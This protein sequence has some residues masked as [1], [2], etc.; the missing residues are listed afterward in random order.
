MVPFDGLALEDCG[1]NDGEDS[2][3]DALG[4]DF[5]LHEA[6]RATVDLTSNTVGGNHETVF[7][8]GDAPRS[9]ND[10]YQRPAGVYLHFGEF[11][12]PVPRKGH[13]NIAD[14]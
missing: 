11:K 3:R 10:K 5:Q 2:Q 13:E 4:K 8:E 1:D 9:D 12:V 6:E 14:Y 7:E